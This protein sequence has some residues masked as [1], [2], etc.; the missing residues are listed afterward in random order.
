MSVRGKNTRQRP[1]SIVSTWKP[2]AFRKL[3]SLQWFRLPFRGWALPADCNCNWKTVTISACH[4]NAACRGN[5]NGKLPQLSGL[6]ICQQPISSKCSQYFLN[7]DRDKV[8]LMGIQLNSVFT[9]LGIIWE[10][11]TLMI[12]YS[13]DVYIR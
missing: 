8:Q 6:G 5:F 4:R 9:A 13:S 7:I 12:M 11:P 3:R 2:M 1:L 10:K